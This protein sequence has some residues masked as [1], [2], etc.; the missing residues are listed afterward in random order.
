MSHLK[1]FA[2]EIENS[3][4]QPLRKRLQFVQDRSIAAYME[5]LEQAAAVDDYFEGT[6]DTRRRTKDEMARTLKLW[7][8]PELHLNAKEVCSLGM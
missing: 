6:L 2:S 5:A 7:R 8:K 3:I 4:F 1:D